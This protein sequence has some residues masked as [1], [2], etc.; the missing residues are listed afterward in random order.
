VSSDFQQLVLNIAKIFG[1]NSEVF[2]QKLTT[3][4]IIVRKEES[5]INLTAAQAQDGVN[6]LVKEIYGRIFGYIVN[7]A[8]RSLASSQFSRSLNEEED[9][10][11]SSIGLLDIFGFEKF[12]FNSFEQLCIN[13]ANEKLQQYFLNYVLKKEQDLYRSEGI[14]YDFQV[15]MDNL[16]VLALFEDRKNGIFARLDDEIKL[17]KAT[18]ET[19]IKKLESDH[20]NTKNPNRRFIKDVKM[21]TSQFEIRHFAG[22]IRYDCQGFLEKNRDKLY[23]HLEELFYLSSNLRF[24][25]LMVFDSNADSAPELSMKERAHSKDEGNNQRGVFSNMSTISTRFQSQLAEL[26]EILN[27]SKP[28]FIK[29]IKPNNMK[30]E[31]LFEKEVVLAQL[32]YSGVLEAVAVRKSGYPTRRTHENFWKNYW[33]LS[34]DITRLQLFSTQGDSEKC[35]LVVKGLNLRNIDENEIKIG[36]TLVFLKSNTLLI[37]EGLKKEKRDFILLKLQA[38]CRGNRSRKLFETM[39]KT[40]SKIVSLVEAADRISEQ[41][42]LFDEVLCQLTE[43]VDY[44]NSLRM[45]LSLIHLLEVSLNRILA[46]KDCLDQLEKFSGTFSKAAGDQNESE[47]D[48]I[49]KEYQALSTLLDRCQTYTVKS[50][51]IPAVLNR[52]SLLKE[53]ADL[54]HTLLLL[55]D[56]GNE[57][58]IRQHLD[59][60]KGLTQKYGN[61]CCK[62]IKNAETMLRIITEENEVWGKISKYLQVYFERICNYNQFQTD[63]SQI[64]EDFNKCLSDFQYQE[65]HNPNAVAWKNGRVYSQKIKI[66]KNVVNQLV[67]FHEHYIQKNW[68]ESVSILNALQNSVNQLLENDEELSCISMFNNIL[69][70]E[71]RLASTDLL[72]NYVLPKLFWSL[73]HGK[74][75]PLSIVP[76]PGILSDNVDSSKIDNSFLVHVLEEMKGF[77]HFQKSGDILTNLILVVERLLDIRTNFLDGLWEMVILLSET[78]DQRSQRLQLLNEWY[79]EMKAFDDQIEESFFY[80]SNLLVESIERIYDMVLIR[81]ANSYEFLSKILEFIRT[82]TSF[83]RKFSLDR[84]FINKIRYI[85]LADSSSTATLPIAESLCSSLNLYEKVLSHFQKFQNIK[86]YN[87]EFKM[88]NSLK[89]IIDSMELITTIRKECRDKNWSKLMKLW[90]DKRFEG[91]AEFPENFHKLNI[92]SQIGK[93]CLELL[94]SQILSLLQYFCNSYL[95]DSIKKEMKENCITL[96]I[97]V[98]TLTS[99]QV[100]EIQPLQISHEWETSRQLFLQFKELL[101]ELIDAKLEETMTFMDKFVNL[102]ATFVKY[103]HS[104]STTE[105]EDQLTSIQSEFQEWEHL[106]IIEDLSEDIKNELIEMK[107]ALSCKSQMKTIFEVLSDQRPKSLD[108]DFDYLIPY[109]PSI[110]IQNS[111]ARTAST[112]TLSNLVNSPAPV[113]LKSL[114]FDIGLSSPLIGSQIS[115]T[116]IEDI[117]KSDGFMLHDSALDMDSSDVVCASI[118]DFKD[119]AELE[120]RE[121]P[122][123]FSKWARCVEGVKYIREC[124]LKGEWIV[125][126][127]LS[128]ELENLEVYETFALLEKE[129]RVNRHHLSNYSV[130]TSCLNALS[131]A[132]PTG[133]IGQ[134]DYKNVS[135]DILEE[136]IKFCQSVGRPSKRAEALFN[137]V[138]TILDLRKAQKLGDWTEIRSVLTRAYA[139][140][141]GTGM[142]D[143]CFAEVNRAVIER[144]N[145]DGIQGLKASIV[146]EEVLTKDSML[147]VDNIA[148]KELSMAVAKVASMPDDTRGLVLKALYGLADSILKARKAVQSRNW[149]V[150]ENLLPV[151]RENSESLQNELDLKEKSGPAANIQRKTMFRTSSFHRGTILNSKDKRLEGPNAGNRGSIWEEFTEVSQS[152]KRELKAMEH[153]FAIVDLEKQLVAALISGGIATDKIGG[154]D[155]DLIKVDDLKEAIDQAS[156]LDLSSLSLPRHLK[157]LRKVGLLIVDLRQGVLTNQWDSMSSLIEETTLDSD[158]S[159][160]PENCRT[161]IQVVRREVE[162]RWIISNLTTALQNGKPTGTINDVRIQDISSSHL[163]SYISTAKSLNPF[164]EEAFKLIASAEK[165]AVLREMIS[166]QGS[167]IP[168][169]HNWSAIKKFA[170][171]TL[172]ESEKHN[173]LH[174][175]ILPELRLILDVAED[176]IIRDVVEQALASGVTSGEPGKIII[177]NI[178]TAQLE[179]AYQQGVRASLKTDYTKLVLSICRMVQRLRE[180]LIRAEKANTNMNYDV[181]VESYKTVKILLAEI[182]ELRK[183]NSQSELKGCWDL[184]SVELELISKHAFLEELKNSLIES[185]VKA[186]HIYNERHNASLQSDLSN[187]DFF[188]N[189]LKNLCVELENIIQ[190]ALGIN[191]SSDYLQKYVACATT[192]RLYRSAILDGNWEQL[193]ILIKDSSFQSNLF[194]LQETKQELQWILCELHN[195]IAIKILRTALELPLA[196]KNSST[197]DNQ[198]SGEEDI[199]SREWDLNML[200]GSS[201]AARNEQLSKAIAEAKAYKITSNVAFQWL[202]CCEN[203]YSLRSCLEKKD[204]VKIAQALRWFKSNAITLPSFIKLEAQRAYVIHQ[205]DLLLHGLLHSLQRGKPSGRCGAINLNLIETQHIE[206]LLKQAK[207]ISPR[208][209]EVDELIAAANTALVIRTALKSRNI[210]ALKDIVADLSNQET[211]ISLQII[212]EVAVAKGEL[213]NDITVR[214]LIKSLRSFEDSESKTLDLTFLRSSNTDD[215][216]FNSFSES[217]DQINR[218]SDATEL[219]SVVNFSVSVDENLLHGNSPKKFHSSILESFSPLERRYSFAN[220]HNTNIDLDSIDIEILDYGLR[221]A[222]DHGIYSEKAKLLYNTVKLIKALRMALKRSDWYV[223][224]ET[225]IKAQYE[226]NVNEI[227]D[228]IASKEIQTLRS[229]LLM[230]TAIVDLSKALKFGWAQCNHGI[231]DT[232]KMRNDLLLNAIE[233]ADHC[234]LELSH[235]SG[236]SSTAYMAEDPFSDEETLS[237]L[238]NSSN[239]GVSRRKSVQFAEDVKP[240][241]ARSGKKNQAN[242]KSSVE[243]QVKLLI[244]SA[245][246]IYKIRDILSTGNMELAGQLAEDGLNKQILHYAVIEELKLYAKEINTALL[247]MKL[248][249]NCKQCINNGKILPIESI[250]KTTYEKGIHFSADLGIVNMILKAEEKL[251]QLLFIRD[252]LLKARGCYDIYEIRSLILSAS[253]NNYQDEELFQLKKRLDILL[254]YR[255]RVFLYLIRWVYNNEPK[256][257]FVE[258]LR[259]AKEME[260]LQHPLT[261][262][263]NFLLKCSC[264]VLNCVKLMKC[265]KLFFPN[266]ALFEKLFFQKTLNPSLVCDVEESFFNSSHN[267]AVSVQSY[268]RLTVSYI[269]HVI[270]TQTIQMKKLFYKLPSSNLKYNLENFPNL[271]SIDDYSYRMSIN[272]EELKKTFLTYSDQSIPC[273]LT[274]LS[275]QFSAVAIVLFGQIIC[276]IE[277]NMFSY[278]EILL[279]KLIIIGRTVLCLRD[280]IYLQIIKQIRNHPVPEKRKKQANPFLHQH[281]QQAQYSSTPSYSHIVGKL[282]QQQQMQDYLLQQQQQYL[283]ATDENLDDENNLRVFIDT[284]EQKKKAI[285]SL[286]KLFMTCL[287]YFPPSAVFES[288]LELFLWKQYD[289]VTSILTGFLIQQ[290]KS[291]S[292][293]QSITNEVEYYFYKN[294][295]HYVMRCIRYLHRAVFLFGNDKPIF[296]DLFHTE[297]TEKISKKNSALYSILQNDIS[298]ETFKLWLLEEEYSDI[299]ITANSTVYY[300]ANTNQSVLENQSSNHRENSDLESMTLKIKKFEHFFDP[301]LPHFKL[302][303]SANPEHIPLIDKSYQSEILALLSQGRFDISQEKEEHI[304]AIFDNLPDFDDSYFLSLLITSLNLL[305]DDPAFEKLKFPKVPTFHIEDSVPPSTVQSNT[306]KSDEVKGASVLSTTCLRGTREDW[307]ERF[308]IFCSY[309]VE[310]I[311]ADSRALQSQSGV[312]TTKKDSSKVGNISRNGSKGDLNNKNTQ[313]RLTQS[314]FCNA[315]AS[316]VTNKSSNEEC[317]M[318]RLD[319][320]IFYFLLFGK[321]SL[322]RSTIIREYLSDPMIFH[323]VSPQEQVNCDRR[324]K[325]L[326]ENLFVPNSV[327]ELFLSQLQASDL[328]YAAEKFWDMIVEKMAKECQQFPNTDCTTETD[329]V[330]P[331]DSADVGISKE[332][333][334]LP[335]S[336][337]NGKE[338]EIAVVEFSIGWEVYREI[339]LMGMKKYSEQ[340]CMK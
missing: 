261:L 257:A 263:I 92:H 233:K 110:A 64:F 282:H 158:F 62:E 330:V 9:A 223:L 170:K 26:V 292:D 258:V 79:Y 138:L 156:N 266:D 19:F 104:F 77:L 194:V 129:I 241:L 38:F 222:E 268:K 128:Q 59:K 141:I 40:R 214:A 231:V 271:R 332:V 196:F 149:F 287:F 45:P 21:L 334:S 300:D 34:T 82:E 242:L 100:S 302:S 230:R 236:S 237:E 119:A 29:C 184:V 221:V 61:F 274:K 142:T 113:R 60:I 122:V 46:I 238:M 12:K 114:S 336:L 339:L 63:L 285:L 201:F 320:D 224:E 108:T 187:H 246:L 200:S 240:S 286:W 226:E 71:S 112:S 297:N 173:K 75:I 185:A 123:A 195:N 335:S 135:T 13:Y 127:K 25:E 15:P 48:Q 126:Q 159:T 340:F 318:D 208:L 51:H 189:E 164:T 169:K 101:P 84:F 205:N 18:D 117:L 83:L 260:L 43:L 33:M 270:S 284:Q 303:K 333:N 47:D 322:N 85:I 146:N 265:F 72:F 134:G 249:E 28:H 220:K 281:Q 324:K 136:A 70:V 139:E 317:N 69:T 193:E 186:S 152:I 197:S 192:L 153:H 130:I 204:N 157:M 31:H 314:R 106:T 275:P 20:N 225:L 105:S 125:A 121:L 319:R 109:E 331:A 180:V 53:R 144:D 42:N 235:T 66:C 291:D 17:P 279:K 273:S 4:S 262:L 293:V 215:V 239:T 137:A 269:A 23:D 115:S 198:S 252:K 329:V 280:E 256:E 227:Y 310:T 306:L 154:I 143:V 163:S 91:Y 22:L 168:E 175:I 229:Q 98:C 289:N 337:R 36:R 131:K 102:R 97:M 11:K 174:K 217:T 148:T 107:L 209:A 172:E 305:E 211:P 96:E 207:D 80:D 132:Q 311:L 253:R 3:R 312:P 216:Q 244:N 213:D 118:K 76:T 162:N 2:T 307:M 67:L 182:E 88:S 308:R 283:S 124:V 93:E 41:S 145:F 150:L 255:K 323:Y 290:H 165:I 328:Y 10:V 304:S 228:E 39:K 243:E 248:I 166:K 140:S 294:I 56:E 276:G 326:D 14:N 94:K 86:V 296:T 44:S 188:M 16:D 120:E 111:R 50:V 6:A 295:R 254:S 264:D 338:H 167:S 321:K 74:I 234:I 177:S 299:T 55:L 212:D 24:R 73:T 5:R 32:K 288:Y 309:S 206:E 1:W 65:I 37:L 247:S 327:S 95:S 210:A 203:M 147:D 49:L 251:Q 199:Y 259:L 250:L 179:K 35:A 181:S 7:Q 219:E 218:S 87:E 277:R 155:K 57:V 116:Q 99:D 90:S 54:I 78:I 178:S 160:M 272:S 202:E 52:I 190:F 151:L 325:W 27:S 301:S 183:E 103:I 68:S 161:E 89:Y 58:L 8:N 30:Q 191:F 315:L 245:K 313:N 81:D 278:K 232:S 176:R 133:L 298:I 316:T 267:T 171:D